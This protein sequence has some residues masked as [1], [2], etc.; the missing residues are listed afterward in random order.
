M[1]F[2]INAVPSWCLQEA[3]TSLQQDPG[4]HQMLPRFIAFASEGVKINVVQNNLALLIYLMRMVKS[5]LDNQTVYLDK[6]V[7]MGFDFQRVSFFFRL[8]FHLRSKCLRMLT[9]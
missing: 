2:D 5:M 7:S 6:Y 3:L 8:H 4:L 9:L 1:R